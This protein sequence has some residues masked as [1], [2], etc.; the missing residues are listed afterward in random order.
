MK[1]LFRTASLFLT[2]SCFLLLTFYTAGCA[3]QKAEC[4]INDEC[5]AT[6]LCLYRKCVPRRA[7]STTDAGNPSEKGIAFEKTPPPAKGLRQKGQSCDPRALAWARDRCAP[8]LTCATLG[9]RAPSA[10]NASSV[11]DLNGA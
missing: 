11:L 7:Q 9:E 1:R 8:G 10:S 2:L 4:Y 5:A 6:H 3:S